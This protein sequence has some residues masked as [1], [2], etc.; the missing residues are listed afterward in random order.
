ML[1]ELYQVLEDRKRE[2]PAGSYTAALLGQGQDQILRKI[3][4]ETFELIQAAS[5]E[6]DARLVQ[7]SADLLYHWL[8]LLV[9]RDIPLQS[10]WR[11][12]EAR[13]GTDSPAD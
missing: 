3:N 10:V 2:T 13:R 7:E 8:V 11:E 6:G 1:D 9:A 12:L 4:E 5:I